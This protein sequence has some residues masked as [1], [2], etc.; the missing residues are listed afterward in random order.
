MLN[1]LNSVIRRK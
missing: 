1:L